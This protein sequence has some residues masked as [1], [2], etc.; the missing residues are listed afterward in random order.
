MRRLLRGRTPHGADDGSMMMALLVSI[1]VSGLVALITTTAIAGQKG[2]RLDKE[3]T[4]ALHA[5]DAGVDQA[6]FRVAAVRENGNRIPAAAGAQV[7]SPPLAGGA[8]FSWYAERVPNSREWVVHSTGTS[9]GKD[10]HLAVTLREDR[11]FFASAFANDGVTFNGNNRADSYSSGSVG[12]PVTTPRAGRLGLV[13]S[14]GPVSFLGNSTVVDGVQLW[15]YGPGTDLGSRCTGQA[16]V[17]LAPTI[18]ACSETAANTPGDYPYQQ[19]Y[20]ER[21]ALTPTIEALQAKLAACGPGPYSDLNITS[22]TPAS[23][24]VL[25]PYFGT[26]ESNR[27][28]PAQ[29]TSPV[30]HYCYNN[31]TIGA[32]VTLSAPPSADAASR[33]RP[34]VLYITGQLKLSGNARKLNCPACVNDRDATPDAGALQIYSTYQSVGS[35]NGLDTSPQNKMSFAFYGPRASCGGGS[36]NEVYGSIICR[37]IDNVG[38]WQFHYDEALE[39]L[40]NKQYTVTKYQER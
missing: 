5:A 4:L 7:V 19:R 2:V 15:H 20:R 1:M 35:L 17:G 9:G 12:Y 28:A 29:G 37:R 3:Y 38:G 30:G 34:V 14:N 11:L 23:Q 18:N 25:A 39:G 40:G 36:G 16:S 21:R 10:R 31:V 33:T 27:S 24:R 32:D 22:T 13:G 6:R 8:S 26:G